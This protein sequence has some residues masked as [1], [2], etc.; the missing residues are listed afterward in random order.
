MEEKNQSP[1]PGLHEPAADDGTDGGEHGRP[2]GP[3][4]DGA[5]AFLF[6]KGRR[7]DG[8]TLGDE[9]RGAHSLDGARG[10]ELAEG[11]RSGTSHGGES[12]ERDSPQVGASPAVTVADGAP[13]Q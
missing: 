12:K 6:G 2:P 5:A 8:K 7:E 9:Q 10:D 13:K 1:G 3:G 4:T 11:I